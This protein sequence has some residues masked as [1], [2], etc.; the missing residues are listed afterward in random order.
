ML[1]WAYWPCKE[2]AYRPRLATD[3]T[4]SMSAPAF[5]ALVAELIGAPAAR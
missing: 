2:N 5:R 1:A 3:E 4:A